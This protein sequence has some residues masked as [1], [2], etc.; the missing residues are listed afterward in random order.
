MRNLCR[1]DLSKNQQSGRVPSQIGQL[2]DPVFLDLSSN[3]LNGT[4]PMELADCQKLIS[5]KLNDNKYELSDCARSEQELGNLNMLKFLKLPQNQFSGSIPSSVTSIKSLSILDASHNNLEGHVPKGIRNASI[6]WFFHKS[7]CGDY[8]SLPPCY[9]PSAYKNGKK[10]RNLVSAIGIL[11]LVR[12]KKKPTDT[13]TRSGRGV[14]SILNFD[15]RLA[16]E[17]IVSATENFDEK[18]CVGAGC[19]GSVYKAQ[20]QTGGV[21]AVKKLYSTG[22]AVG[23]A[24]IHRGIELLMKIRHHNIVKLYGFCSHG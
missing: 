22:E 15:G 2:N 7:L 9:S 5:I 24:T 13:T 19:Y 11:L 4:I 8:F 20:L 1:L 21:F 18:H 12:Q 10:R 14:F 23:D 6:N 3:Q 16:F 17:D